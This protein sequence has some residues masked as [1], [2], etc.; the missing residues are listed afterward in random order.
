M[1]NLNEKEVRRISKFMSLVLRHKPE[2][3]GLQLDSEGWAEVDELIEK[4]R[5]AGRRIDRPTLDWVVDHNNKKRFA[6]SADGTR[7][8]ASQGHSIKIDLG[9]APVAPPEF[10][11]H[12][13]VDRFIPAIRES[14]IQKM[15]RHAV[16]LSQDQKTAINVGNRRGKALILV[17]RAGE[18]HRAGFSFFVSENG[19][20]LTDKVPAEYIDFA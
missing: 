2:T 20:W 13:T 15:R 10:L 19:V 8:R 14:G 16:H 1:K 4:M 9:Y 18:M 6:F 7:I 12:G 5:R 3:I 11:Y 17:V